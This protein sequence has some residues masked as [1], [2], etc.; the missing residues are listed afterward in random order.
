MSDSGGT[1]NACGVRLAKFDNSFYRP[2]RNLA[3]RMAW[4]FLGL[5]VLRCA[6]LPSSAVRRVLLRAFGAR[7]GRGVVIKAGTR[8]KYP[9]RL[10]IGNN[11]WIG[12]DA[13][14]D[15][16]ADVWIGDDVCVSQAA[17]ICTG[18]HD[19]TDPA[20]GLV[21]KPITLRDGSW[22]GA[23]VTVCPGVEF[24]EGAMAAAGSVVTRSISPWEIHA[25]NP[26]SFVKRR[27]LRTK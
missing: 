9:W 5:P 18:N 22:V 12:E 16:L 21:V 3:V 8:V 19:R 15:N 24:G 7:I 25:G 1:S 17:Y 10:S 20:F 11:S 13:W 6:L 2:G 4:F 26:A 23:R 27:V 14:I